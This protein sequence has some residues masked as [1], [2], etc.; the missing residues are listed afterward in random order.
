MKI[1]SLKDLKKLLTLCREQGVNIIKVDGMELVLEGQPI[2]KATKSIKTTTY[3]PGGITA[4]TK[5]D[6]PDSLTEEQL[7]FYSAGEQQ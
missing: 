2:L 7:L 5:I 6:T 1:E 4:E 3:A